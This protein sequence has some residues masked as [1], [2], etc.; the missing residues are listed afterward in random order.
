MASL[1]IITKVFFILIFFYLCISIL[2]RWDE[3][4]P[5]KF[6]GIPINKVAIKEFF[7]VD[8]D[9]NF[10]KGLKQTFSPE[11]LFGPDSLFTPLNRKK[12]H[13]ESE[14]KKKFEFEKN[15]KCPNCG[16]K[17]IEIKN[18]DLLLTNDTNFLTFWRVSDYWSRVSVSVPGFKCIIC[19]V[20]CITINLKIEIYNMKNVAELKC[21]N[22]EWK[23]W[24]EFQ[25]IHN[26]ESLRFAP[27]PYPRIKA[28]KY[29]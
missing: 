23:R 6:I 15:L 9:A 26:Y 25:I 17:E 7:G 13:D 2:S 14:A 11:I 22:K 1:E 10:I 21:H 16:S 3:H 18:Y 4:T 27:F 5:S 19:N 12:K 28:W 8:D 29:F 24:H 20:K